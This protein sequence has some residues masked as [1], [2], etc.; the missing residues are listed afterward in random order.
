MIVV[1]VM[2][3]GAGA[4]LA[5]ATRGWLEL[6]PQ[7]RAPHHDDRAG[8][9]DADVNSAGADP[10]RRH[11]RQRLAVLGSSRSLAT[12]PSAPFVELVGGAGAVPMA[13]VM[14]GATSAA[15]LTLLTLLY[16][17][18]PWQHRPDVVLDASGSAF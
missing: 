6:W 11:R 16:L 4:V 13:V 8:S 14:V 12:A 2:L 17:R 18:R 7:P 10:P 5:C 15:L 1:V 9:G 3:P